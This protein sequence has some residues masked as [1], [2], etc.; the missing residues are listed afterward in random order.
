MYDNQ[1]QG[2]VILLGTLARYID[3]EDKVRSISQRL[4][5]ALKTPSQKVGEKR[6]GMRGGRDGDCRC[7]KQC[8]LVSPL[9]YH[10]F[11]IHM[12]YSN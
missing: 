2:L 11:P 5:E 4:V 8:P 6:R 9:S 10:S 7:K 12:N 1:R 3:N